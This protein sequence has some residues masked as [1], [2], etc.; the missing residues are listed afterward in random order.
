[1]S[2]LDKGGIL[3]LPQL[4]VRHI[5]PEL[6]KALSIGSAVLAAPPGSG[7]TTL[8]PLALLGEPWLA[9][10]KILILEPRRLAARAAAGRMASLIGESI[11]QTVGYQI[12]FDRQIS[13]V[14]R[15]E[16][17]TEGILTRRL[18][19][20]PDLKGVGLIVF[21]EF[22]ERSIHADLALSLCLDL[23]QL[24]DDLRLL[25]M[26]ATL[27]T[28]PVAALLGDV[29]IIIGEGKSHEVRVEYLLRQAMGRIG[30]R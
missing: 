23:C 14:T 18:Q 28:T 3:Q 15:I 11:G 27:D 21:D 7:K 16:V 2:V 9:D 19:S 25:I 29:P 10:K 24:R 5:L 12:R 8:V 13:S 17:L 20:D 30:G 6:K 22:H 4:P 26:S 1:M